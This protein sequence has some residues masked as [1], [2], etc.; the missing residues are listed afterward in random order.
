MYIMLFYFEVTDLDKMMEMMEMFK[1]IQSFTERPG[2]QPDGVFDQEPNRKSF[3]GMVQTPDLMSMK[4]AMQYLHPN[5]QKTLSILIK[6]IEIQRLLA[7]FSED[8]M[9]MPIA[10]E[11]DW[12]RN[13]LVSVRPY[14]TPQ[15][16]G[17]LDMLVK[18]VDIIAISKNMDLQNYKI[19]GQH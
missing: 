8:A 1:M 9:A 15:K 14:M 18:F 2:N 11:G 16:Q 6:I 10:R 19:G 12:R 17:L 4:A 3:D 13:M 7:V 5:M